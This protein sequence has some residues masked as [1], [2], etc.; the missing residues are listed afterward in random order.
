MLSYVGAKSLLCS[1]L[2]PSQML[3]PIILGDYWS[4]GPSL[5]PQL[6][7]QGED[8]T[9]PLQIHP[10]LPLIPHSTPKTELK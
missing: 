7:P 9:A 10:N 8:T 3:L 2:L 1:S 4:L 5:C 6:W